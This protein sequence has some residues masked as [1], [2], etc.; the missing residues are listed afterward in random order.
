VAYFYFSFTDSIKQHYPNMLRS[1]LAQVA[2]QVDIIPD[3]LISLYRAYQRSTPPTDALTKALRMLVD[4]K[5]FHHVYVVVDALD[6]IPDTDERTETCKILDEVS[7]K[8]R[9]HVITTS[10]R[11]HDIFEYMSERKTIRDISIQ[12]SEVDH[13]I[14]LWIRERLKED[15]KLR[16]WSAIHG[17]IEAA[18]GKEAD[19]M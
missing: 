14:K 15:K 10:R 3:C 6:E 2:S 13:D 18:L 5:F 7:Q 16:K 1:L 8:P 11:E 4:E 12:N 17:E 19:G 9:A